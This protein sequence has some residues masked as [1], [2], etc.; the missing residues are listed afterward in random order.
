MRLSRYFAILAASVFSLSAPLAAH[1]FWISP[2]RY[3]IAPGEAI[4]AE[5]RVGENLSGAGYPYIPLR[6]QQHFVLQNGEKI[7]PN[8]RLGDR[9]ALNI[10]LASPGLAIIVHET[11]NSLLTYR[12]WEKF[13]AF[14]QHKDLTWALQAHAARGL[15]ETGFRESYRR[16]GKSLVAVGDGAGTDTEVGLLT[17]IIA[18]RNPYTSSLSEGLPVQVLA[19]GAPRAD[20]QVELFA[21]S[22]E[23]EVTVTLHRTDAAGQVTLPMDPD[24]E[25][26]V[27]AVFI[28][29]RSGTNEGDPVWHSLWASLSFRTPS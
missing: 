16:Y 20:A 11:S 29:E 28:E 25:Y 24:T 17:E 5:L 1:E 27:D 13:R 4:L 7:E 6:A 8:S 3:Q 12:D 10:E 15:P 26:L 19:Y 14:T 22:S 2:E 23:G 18:L 9:P 21:R